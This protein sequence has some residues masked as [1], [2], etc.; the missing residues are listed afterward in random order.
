MRSAS[1]YG[2]FNY[3]REG[4]G[5]TSGDK[6][7]AIIG[8]TI[9]LLM[10]GGIAFAA[11]SWNRQPKDVATLGGSNPVS[12]GPSV[13]SN[14]PSTASY[15]APAAKPVPPPQV[16]YNSPP[17]IAA[18]KNGMSTASPESVS[19]AVASNTLLHV[20]EA[21]FRVAKTS[22]GK[23]ILYGEADIDNAASSRIDNA[24]FAL[25][26]GE[27]TLLLRVYSGEIYHPQYMEG[28]SIPMGKSTIF[29]MNDDAPASIL[30]G[31]DRTLRVDGRSA[32]GPVEGAILIR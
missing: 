12:S 16:T 28:F 30:R 25:K 13:A 21:R 3:V 15:V 8:G 24:R 5:V 23:Y 14:G 29:L 18:S 6:M 9:L 31:G 26:I 1:I 32:D 10:I 4:E 19:G 7:T 22:E 27:G 17:A 11:V 20:A 2:S